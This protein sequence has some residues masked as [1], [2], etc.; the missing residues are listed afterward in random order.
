MR[1]K[2]PLTGYL[3]LTLVRS[4]TRSTVI[5]WSNCLWL[6][7]T[8]GWRI[9]ICDIGLN[10]LHLLLCT[11][12][13]LLRRERLPDVLSVRV[14]RVLGEEIEVPPLRH[15]IVHFLQLLADE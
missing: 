6:D 5:S 14:Q 13:L 2:T 1:L 9:Q 11:A 12:L 7:G 8:H 4:R 15:D 10:W 3:P